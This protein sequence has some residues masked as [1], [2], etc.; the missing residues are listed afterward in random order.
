MVKF[1]SILFIVLIMLLLQPSAAFA[2]APYITFTVNHEGEPILTQSAYLPTGVVDGFDI[3]E[4][5]AGTGE[6]SSV[7]LSR[8]EDLFIDSQDHVYVADTGNGRIV[9]FDAWGNYLRSIGQ[10]VLSKPTGVFVDEEGTVYAADYGNETVYMFNKDG[11]LLR[12]FGKPDSHLFGENNPFKPTKVIADKRK[13]LFIVGEGTIHGLIQ[14]SQEGEFLGY[15]GGNKTGFS[16]KRL[17]QRTFYTQTQLD[18]LMKQ[19]PPSATNVAI[20]SEGLVYTSTIGTRNDS[21]KKLNVAGKNLLPGLWSYPDIADVTV[22]AMGN[23]YVVDSFRGRIIEYD[24]D[25]NMLFV[26]GGTDE[27]S[28]R[29]GLFKSPSGIAVSSDGRLFVVDKQR[30]NI[31]ILKPTEFTTIVHEAIFHYM[32]G[33][34]AQSEGPWI[35]VLR[36]NSMFDLAHTGLG[37]AAMK[38]GNYELALEEF[39][40]AGNKEE[41]SNAYWE[42][43][44]VWLMENASSFMIG[45][46]LLLAVIT[47]MRKLYRKY[48]FAR[49]AVDGWKWFRQRTLVAQLLHPFRLMRHPVDGYYELEAEGK[50]SVLSATILLLLLFVVRVFEIYQTNFLFADWDVKKINLFTEFLKVYIPFFA[51]VISNYLVSTIND[52]EGKFKDIYKGSVYA[53]SP[54]II[55]AGPVAVMSQGLTQLEVVVYD[56]ASAAIIIYSVFLFFMMVKEIHGYEIGQ[57]VKNIF[58]TIMGMLIMALLAF[59]LFGLSNQ[60]TDFIYSI[61]QEVKYRVD[62]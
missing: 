15:F 35:D 51:W 50:S 19:L 24:R 20:D 54:Y 8:P 17:L 41:Y 32:D 34:Y 36:L 61:F 56:F 9:V 28:Q 4:K 37:M 25:G 48:G 10:E 55:F 23:I 62:Y 7:P 43:R 30:N 33:K 57:T 52:G 47:A 46:I 5:D 45:I 11:S 42:I 39:S 3:I 38:L 40:V 29:L 16:L 22:D 53:L 60:V 21:I 31:Q 27:G 14:I 6:E 1:K 58:L 18:Q 13:N 49:Q 26:F 59:I 12:E 2:N 44:R